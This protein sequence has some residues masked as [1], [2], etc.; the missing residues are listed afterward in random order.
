MVC[1]KDRSIATPTGRTSITLVRQLRKHSDTNWG[2]SITL[3]RQLNELED[4]N[5][6]V[7]E[8]KVFFVVD[9]MIFLLSATFIDKSVPI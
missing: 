6:T 5:E 9:N 2:T 3:V 4:I 7:K 8:K 1:V